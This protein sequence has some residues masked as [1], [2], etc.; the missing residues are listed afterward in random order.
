MSGVD[1]RL[2]EADESGFIRRLKTVQ[3][4]A[5]GPTITDDGGRV[6]KV[7]GDGVLVEF[8]SGWQDH[9]SG[10]QLIFLEI[11]HHVAASPDRLDVSHPI[12]V[13]E[14]IA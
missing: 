12:R 1:S 10:S 4:D 8:G 11:G 13:R 9:F 14:L 6:V 7:M 5:I 2:V 3:S